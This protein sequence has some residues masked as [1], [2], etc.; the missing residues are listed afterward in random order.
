MIIIIKNLHY[1]LNY[2]KEPPMAVVLSARL[3]LSNTNITL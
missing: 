3:K 2:K 1:F